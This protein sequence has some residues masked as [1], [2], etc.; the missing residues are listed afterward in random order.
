MAIQNRRG[1]F[2][3]FDPYKMLAGEFAYSLDTEEL[4]YC[5]SPG[6]V[7]RCAT[8]E[9][10][11][12]VLETNQEAYDGLQQLLTEL[13]NET[14]ANG[15][16]NDILDLKNRVETI[17]TTP[18]E[19]VSEQE[20]IDSRQG[21]ISLGANL[22]AIKDEATSLKEDYANYKK[23]FHFTHAAQEYLNIDK[24]WEGL[25]NGKIYTSEF[26]HF[27]V[28]PSSDGVKKDDNEGLICEPS[29]NTIRGR[30]DYE[31]I[32]LFMSIDVNAYV[33]ENDDYHVVAINGDGRFKRD[34][35]MGD[36]YVMAM[37]GYQRRYSDD[38]VWGISYSDTMHAGYEILD[39]AVK[40]DGTIRP[41]LLHAKYVAGR[42]PLENNNLASISGV[43]AEYVN[44]SHNGQI[45]EFAKK[46]VQYSGKTSHD[47]YYIQL[48]M[49]LKYA[50]TNSDTIMKGCQSYYLQYTN[51]VAE[52]GVNRVIIT[53]AQANNLLVGST[54]SI[55]DYGTGSI[56]ADRQSSQNY[57]VKE[58]VEITY[59]EDLGNGTSAVYV[60]S[61]IFDTTLTTTIATYPWNSGGCDGVLGQDGSPYNTQSGKEPFIINGIEMMIGGYE[62]L[63]N[64]I[65]HNNNADNRTDVYANYDCRTYAT[66]PTGDYDLVGQIVATGNVW[67]YGSKMVISDAHP[68][69]ILVTETEASSTT[70]TGDGIYTNPPSAGG[71]R[72]WQ[73][74]GHLAYGAI[75]GFRSLLAHRSL[76]TASWSVLGRLSATG[77][78][79]RRSLG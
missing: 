8:K 22:T 70:G 43:P 39:E 48:M 74:L 57:N 19:G 71:Y 20:I 33:D 63:Q 30:N 49:W 12:E 34:G 55:G 68:P 15:I 18:A 37:P 58:R 46:G 51:L 76:A 67:K 53:N 78:S 7:K 40:P 77:R 69:I 6:N 23:P 5:V 54:V 25:K 29:T 2:V 13:E 59:I 65:I 52:A 66:S 1:N 4:Y 73:S 26:Y 16:L 72:E 24:F 62:I 21:H 41:Y 47:D 9:D 56:N 50:T 64:L 79:R 17:I 32:G 45:T 75:C 60:A 61:E 35:T 3:D 36:V 28:S 10:I 44:M 14:V 38:T 42:N 11:I 31:K 27:D